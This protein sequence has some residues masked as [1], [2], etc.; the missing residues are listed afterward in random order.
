MSNPFQEQFL[1]MGL[2]TKKQVKQAK[3]AGYIKKKKVDS[4][5]KEEANASKAEQALAEKRRQDKLLNKQRDQEHKAKQAQARLKQLIET[6]RLSILNGDT[7]YKFSHNNKVQSIAVTKSMVNRLANGELA[8]VSTG[9]E[10]CVVPVGLVK[11]IRAVNE[12]NIIVCHKKKKQQAQNE[13]DPYA[14]YQVPDDLMW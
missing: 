9:K 8:I 2:A 10:Y 3:K 5:D 13:S 12:E 6:N 11:K 1:K 14:E 7:P 4:S